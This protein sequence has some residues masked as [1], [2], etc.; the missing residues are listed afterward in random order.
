MSKLLKTLCTPWRDSNPGSSV[1]VTEVMATALQG[2]FLISFG[3]YFNPLQTVTMLFKICFQLQYVMKGVKN[4]RVYCKS[5][6][7]M[8]K[9]VVQIVNEKVSA[10]LLFGEYF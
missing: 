9:H 6:S 4:S 7:S 2:L 10:S 8:C 3:E 5:N 1:L